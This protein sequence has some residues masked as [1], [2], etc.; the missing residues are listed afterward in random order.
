MWRVCCHAAEGEGQRSQR[1]EDQR[2][3]SR[4]LA[5]GSYFR[6]TFRAGCNPNLIVVQHA[7]EV[8][9]SVPF[10]SNTGKVNKCVKVCIC[11][12]VLIPM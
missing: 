8:E 10:F 1:G 12:C 4:G 11:V 9:R 2:A 3:W 5:L 7:V 6:S